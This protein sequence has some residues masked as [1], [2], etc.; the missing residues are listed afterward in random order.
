MADFKQRVE[1]THE[2]NI[3][4]STLFDKQIKDLL[5]LN[6][7]LSQDAKGLSEALKGNKKIQ[8]NWG[9]FQ[10]ERVLEISGLQKGIN[11]VVQET[12][13][14]ENNQMLRPDVIIEL[15]NDRKVIIDS[16]VSLNDY[17]NFVNSE[18]ENE[19]KECLK[20]HIQCIKNHIDELSSKEYQKLLKGSML[21]YVV[22]FIPIESAYVEAVR[23]D[24][25]LGRPLKINPL[26][27]KPPLV[28]LTSG[29]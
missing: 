3:K 5:S 9:E 24:T 17:V 29:S 22:I 18:D 4:N 19:R 11:F 16:K 27:N 14:N 10:L 25:T 23:E 26:S 6:Q 7:N 1:Q 2:E 8:G 20:K 12:F 15:P 28:I 21:D 13:R